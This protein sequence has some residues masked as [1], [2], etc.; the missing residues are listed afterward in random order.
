MWYGSTITWDSG[1][2]EMIHVINHAVSDNGHIWQRNGLA[3][4]YCLGTAQAF[5]RP[6]IIGNKCSGYEMWFSYR[7]RAGTK[8]RIGYATSEDGKIWNL[9]LDQVGIN[10]S[11][12]DWDSEMIEYPFVFDHNGQRFMLYNGNSYGRTGFGLAVLT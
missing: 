12:S 5:S 1:N 6:S 10:T 8:Y 7:G 2:G 11:P 4:P 3:V 9:K